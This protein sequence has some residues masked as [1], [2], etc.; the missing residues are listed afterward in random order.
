MRYISTRNSKKNLAFK[1][2]FLNALAPD[3]GLYIPENIPVFSGNELD[4]LRKFSYKDLAT[5]IILKFCSKEFTKYDVE[6][7]RLFLE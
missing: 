5:K 1:D 4:E 6:K 7:M 2:I 3:G